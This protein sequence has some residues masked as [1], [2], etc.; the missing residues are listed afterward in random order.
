MVWELRIKAISTLINA[1]LVFIAGSWSAFT[2]ADFPANRMAVAAPKAQI[3]GIVYINIRGNV[4]APPPCKINNGN[5]ITVD[6]GE[7][8]STRIDGDK[9]KK[10]IIYTAECT[11]MPTN[12]MKL[13]I[14]GKT[15]SFDNNA[16][17]TNIGGL[18]VRILYQGRTLAVGQEVKFTYPQ[19]PELAAVP[20]R[21]MS[22]TLT[23]GAFEAVATLQLDYQ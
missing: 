20:V 14:N 5:M 19:F 4:I 21:D 18:G 17:E 9:Y 2:Y 13:S 23:G 12:A 10:D 1:M 15:A 11:K 3:P 7:V 22:A 16:L 8:M 6:F